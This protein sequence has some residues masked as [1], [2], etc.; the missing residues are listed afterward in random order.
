LVWDVSG[1]TA[2]VIA[3]SDAINSPQSWSF[4]FV[5]IPGITDTS[6]TPPDGTDICNG[7]TD[8]SCNTGKIMDQYPDSNFSAAGL[9][10]G[11]TSDNSGEVPPGTWYLPAICQ[12]GGS[13]QG[14]GCSSDL[15]IP[16]NIDTNLVQL[17]FGGLEGTY[18]SSTESSSDPQ[19]LAW[20]Q[21]FISNS[22]S[23]QGHDYKDNPY[24]G[25]RC[26]RAF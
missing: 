24:V 26:S 20:W 25:I 15:P 22:G 13:G 8:G 4:D 16:N 19:Y 11:I 21:Y 5:N 1:S 10:Y 23:N 17:G 6:K 2:Q 7:A 3:T 18:W 9:C 14:A 12:M